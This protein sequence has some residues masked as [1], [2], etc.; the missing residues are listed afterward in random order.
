MKKI[1]VLFFL[2]I[3]YFANSQ[4][5]VSNQNELISAIKSNT[6]II[7]LNNIYIED[8]LIVL[9]S[10]NNLIIEGINS[11]IYLITD[12]VDCAVL[13]FNNSS[14]INIRKLRIGHIRSETCDANVLTF[15][16]TD[17]IN[18]DSVELFGSGT[19][20]IYLEASDNLIIENSY[21]T[22]C[23]MSA[24]SIYNS[25]KVTVN[26]CTFIEIDGQYSIFEFDESKTILFS[27]CVFERNFSENLFFDTKGILQ[28]E[29]RN[30]LIQYNSTAYFDHQDN[31]MIMID[32][33]IT[34]NQF[35]NYYYEEKSP[36]K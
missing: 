24:F 16:K 8:D 28:C 18:I 33:E 35:S 32:C 3:G 10:I 17:N 1:I 14:N 20:G 15:N 4:E 11:N 31:N 22:N 9:D 5:Y 36:I 7:I 21:I 2:I 26:N 19:I 6:H 30:C 13:E 25:G 12:R 34:G 29:L 27:N 23:T